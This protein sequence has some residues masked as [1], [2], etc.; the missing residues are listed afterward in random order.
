MEH[1]RSNIE[2]LALNLVRPPSVVSYAADDGPNVASCHGNGLAIVERLDSSQQ[3]QV[4]LRQVRKLEQQNAALLGCGLAP[5]ALEGLSRSGDGKVDILLCGLTD[6]ADDL[7][8]CGVDDLEGLFVDTFNP[9]VVD[10][11]ATE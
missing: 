4:L 1:V 9:L 3:V 10:E 8:C 6:G 7:L 11:P 2:S 5:D